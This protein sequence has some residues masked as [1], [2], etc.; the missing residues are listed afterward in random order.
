M[1][2]FKATDLILSFRVSLN[3]LI[4]IKTSIDVMAQT[5][6]KVGCHLDFSIHLIFD[7]NVF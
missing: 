4:R 6:D 2:N 5:I 7:K 3:S 1:Y